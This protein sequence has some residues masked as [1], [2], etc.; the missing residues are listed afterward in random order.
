M[1]GLVVSE[2]RVKCILLSVENFSESIYA[3]SAGVV[4]ISGLCDN[5]A[6]YVH[7][8]QLIATP[9]LTDLWWFSGAVLR[10]Y[11]VSD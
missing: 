6:G 9:W 4:S 10:V 3:V 8:V 11:C 5:R 2:L 1:S 7:E